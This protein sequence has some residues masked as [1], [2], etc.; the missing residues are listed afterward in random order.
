[1]N[2]LRPGIHRSQAGGRLSPSWAAIVVRLP[3]LSRP[4]WYDEA[5]AVSSPA[6][7]P[8]RS[9]RH[10]VIRA[11][12]RRTYTFALYTLLWGW[13][14]L[15][16]ASPLAVRFLSLVLGGV[17][18]AGYA[19]A[20]SLGPRCRPRREPAGDLAVQ[21]HYAQEVRMYGLLAFLLLAATGLYGV[22]RSRRGKSGRGLRSG[23]SWPP[24]STHIIWPRS[25]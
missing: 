15:V 24:P 4:L 25:S 2:R 1:V 8:R 11:G 6:E 23:L 10:C 16:G 13:E 18:A 17:V 22:G 20:F 19:V 7:A 12:S 21:V 3:G 14:S 9:L 5:F